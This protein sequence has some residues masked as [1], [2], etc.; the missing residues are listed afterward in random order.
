MVPPLR[1]FVGAG[2]VACEIVGGRDVRH[3][4]SF[5]LWVGL[6]ARVPPPAGVDE[7]RAL[8]RRRED[9]AGERPLRAGAAYAKQRPTPL[10][11]T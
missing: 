2:S 4:V 11:A 3:P 5:R 6:G 8:S 10:N 7:L 1:F 9:A